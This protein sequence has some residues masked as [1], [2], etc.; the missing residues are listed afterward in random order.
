LNGLYVVVITIF[1]KNE[2]QKLIKKILLYNILN[3]HLVINIKIFKSPTITLNDMRQGVIQWNR[4]VQVVERL[5][6]KISNNEYLGRPIISRDTTINGGIYPGANSREAI[7]VDSSEDKYIQQLYQKAKDSVTYNGKID[8]LK[9]LEAVFKIAQ[10]AIFPDSDE[11]ESMIQKF[12]MYDKPI[13]LGFFIK[14][15]IGVCR[16]YALTTGVLLELFKQEKI[17]RGKVSIDRN[18]IGQNGHS[19]T[20]YTSYNG[21]ICIVD[22]AQNFIGT[23]DKAKH[24]AS[25][26]YLR[27]NDK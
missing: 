10:S 5:E 6:H 24:E 15:R 25:W 1:I 16:H 18:S 19:W 9:V 13:Y 7:I 23:L 17:I 11:V 27:P 20:R 26:N 2:Q 4:S 22:A 8:R 14:N 12:N 21:T 3:Y